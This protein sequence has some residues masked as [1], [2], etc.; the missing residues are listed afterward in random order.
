MAFD[1]EQMKKDGVSAH[2][3]EL[4]EMD[5]STCLLR[6]ARRIES[7]AIFQ[8]F[9]G[10][11]ASED[12]KDMYPYAIAAG[13]MSEA[14]AEWLSDE[15]NPYIDMV[16]AYLAHIPKYKGEGDVTLKTS[17]EPEDFDKIEPTSQRSANFMVLDIELNAEIIESDDDYIVINSIVYTEDAEKEIPTKIAQ[18]ISAAIMEIGPEGLVM[19]I[20]E[21]EVPPQE[22]I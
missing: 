2:L 21:P 22:E 3:I 8:Q 12:V 11:N 5:T 16:A 1:I 10:A 6:I 4:A 17:Y 18:A 9:M 20:G 14:D 15:E 13:I 19:F 7:D